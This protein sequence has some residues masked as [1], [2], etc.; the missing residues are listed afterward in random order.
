MT[1]TPAAH[2]HTHARLFTLEFDVA[3]AQRL[4]LLV[5]RLVANLNLTQLG[6][7]RRNLHEQLVVV[8]VRGLP[9]K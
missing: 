4:Q 5:H 7:Q 8:L 3:V 2:A 1:T 6:L 9:T